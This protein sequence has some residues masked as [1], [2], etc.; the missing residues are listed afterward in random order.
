MPS[1][2][3]EKSRRRPVAEGPEVLA[4][5]RLVAEARP[6]LCVCWCTRD[7]AQASTCLRGSTSQQRTLRRGRHAESC[8]CWKG[9][10]ESTWHSIYRIASTRNIATDC[11]TRIVLL[12]GAT[13]QSFCERLR[14]FCK[15]RREFGLG[16]KF[17]FLRDQHFRHFAA[18][19][20]AS[21]VATFEP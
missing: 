4:G 16:C 3:S 6:R 17:A 14:D 7:I 18:W 11:K 13:L 20:A 15:V 1:F 21:S 10:Q 5:R 2:S 12:P 8:F 9:E 19:C